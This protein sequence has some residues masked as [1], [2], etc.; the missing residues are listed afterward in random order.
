M[1]FL[2]L[3]LGLVGI[4]DQTGQTRFAFGV[5]ELM[6]GIDVVVLAVG[7]F[8]V[9][10][11]LYVA[12]YQSRQREDDRE[13]VG[14]A[15]DV[16]RGLEAVVAGVAARH[17][18]RL[19]VRHHSGRRRGDPDLPFVCAGEEAHQVP[20]GIRQRARSRAWPGRRPRTTPRQPACWC[21][22]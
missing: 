7:L 20:R 15:L 13:D 10:E 1:L 18:H 4:D 5:P 11:A 17:L 16:A 19:S 12:A 22:C 3:L 14:L 6:D 2:G 8:A 9:G 21:R